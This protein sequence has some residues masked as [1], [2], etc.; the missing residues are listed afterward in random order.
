[1]EVLDQEIYTSGNFVKDD[2]NVN[3]ILDNQIKFLHKF[4]LNT[5]KKMPFLYWIATTQ[6]TPLPPVYHLWTGMC[7][8]ATFYYG[9]LLFENCA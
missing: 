6:R 8:S 2:R 4:N 7:Y 5:N 3:E 1:M 9:W